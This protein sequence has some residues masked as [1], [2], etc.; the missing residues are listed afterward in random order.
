[1][2]VTHYYWKWRHDWGRVTVLIRNW[3]KCKKRTATLGLSQA[4]TATPTTNA[5]T[6][7]HS[8][9]RDPLRLRESEHLAELVVQVARAR[10]SSKLPT[11]IRFGHVN[12]RPHVYARTFFA[13]LH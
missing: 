11:T 9:G 7:P 5:L 2:R 1:M 4:T 6:S 3:S 10:R 8:L 13:V 12:I